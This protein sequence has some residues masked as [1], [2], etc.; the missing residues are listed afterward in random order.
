MTCCRSHTWIPTWPTQMGWL[1]NFPSFPCCSPVISSQAPTRAQNFLLNSHGLHK[2]CWSL[3]GL[4][5][6]RASSSCLFSVRT[7]LRKKGL[8]RII[9]HFGTTGA[10]LER[11]SSITTRASSTF[12][13]FFSGL[14]HLSSSSFAKSIS[15]TSPRT[16]GWYCAEN[17]YTTYSFGCTGYLGEIDGKGEEMRIRTS[18]GK[19]SRFDTWLSLVFSLGFR[20]WICANTVIAHAFFTTI[21]RV[22]MI[23]NA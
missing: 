3:A 2:N 1:G 13:C 9:L 20:V 12:G 7:D 10:F 17:L 4:Y 5:Q 8:C 11:S 22:K 23:Q 14:G 16:G 19:R 6:W 18:A 21:S 15:S